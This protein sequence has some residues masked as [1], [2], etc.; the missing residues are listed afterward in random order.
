MHTVT[1]P[2]PGAAGGAAGAVTRVAVAGATGYTGQELLRL[3]ARHPSVRITLATSSGA[4]SSARRLPGLAHV[5]DGGRSTLDLL[6]PGLTLLTAGEVAPPA[7]CAPVTVHR[8][9]AVTARALGAP[10][11]G[12]VLVRSDGARVAVLDASAVRLA[13]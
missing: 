3:L 7:T 5:W 10:P 13:A 4:A 1:D 12:A 9:A 8:V 6:S 2:N 11:G